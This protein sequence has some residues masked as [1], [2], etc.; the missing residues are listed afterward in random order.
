MSEYIMKYVS[1]R[2]I[3]AGV[4]ER[5]EQIVRCRDCKHFRI[6]PWDEVLAAQYGAPPITCERT[7]DMDDVEP[8]G[9]CAWGERRVDE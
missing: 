1:K 3:D 8:D 7:G 5:A 9:F 2:M 4:F 6:E